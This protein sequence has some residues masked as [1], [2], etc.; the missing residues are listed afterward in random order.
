MTYKQIK[1]Y[2]DKEEVEKNTDGSTTTT[3]RCEPWLN[4]FLNMVQKCEEWFEQNIEDETDLENIFKIFG[5]GFSD[6]FEMASHLK[7]KE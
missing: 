6:G 5:Q 7:F 3:I 1:A 2:F 4:P